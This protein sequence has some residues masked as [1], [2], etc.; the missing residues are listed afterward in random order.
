MPRRLLFPGPLGRGTPRHSVSR[1]GLGRRSRKPPAPRNRTPPCWW[2][3]PVVSHR[4]IARDLRRR[5]A[6]SSCQVAVKHAWELFPMYGRDHWNEM[7]STPATGGHHHSVDRMRAGKNRSMRRD[8]KG[9]FSHGNAWC[10]QIERGSLV[11]P[12][13]PASHPR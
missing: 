13:G 12:R 3:P 7:R 2:Q 4:E 1:S 8:P 9:Q 10:R 5:C 6:H 11:F